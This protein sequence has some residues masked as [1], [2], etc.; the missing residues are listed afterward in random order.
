MKLEDKK[1][2]TPLLQVRDLI[3]EFDIRDAAL[4]SRTLRAVDGVNF[5]VEKRETFA[6]VGESGSGKSTIGRVLLGL[7]DKSSGEII[8]DQEP[9]SIKNREHFRNIRKRLQIVFQDPVTAFDPRISIGRSLMEFLELRDDL[10]KSQRQLRVDEL[11]NE[12]GLDPDMVKRLPSQMSGG[13]LQRLSVARALAS[14]PDLIFLDEPT[15]ALDV[16]I[17]GQIVNLLME[18]QQQRGV[19]YLLVAHDL[20]VVAVMADRV[21]VMYLG[22]F[23]EISDKNKLFNR[24]LHPYTR[25]LI[26]AAHLDDLGLN[27]EKDSVR[28]SGELSENDAKSIGCRLAPRC[29]FV[30]LKCNEPQQLNELS[31]GQFVRCWKAMDIKNK[32]G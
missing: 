7:T 20:R 29:P 8:F 28:L 18:R 16:S 23:V 5:V 31:P 22:Q 30:E 9:L 17:R 10:D 25:G 2:H 6:I 27:R 19:S 15:S 32:S 1:F 11:I 4:R 26:E 21:A 12:V 3:K 24:P 13:Q 14:E